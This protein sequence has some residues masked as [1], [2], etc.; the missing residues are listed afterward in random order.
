MWSMVMVAATLGQLDP[1]AGGTLPGYDPARWSPPP[2]ITQAVPAGPYEYHRVYDTTDAVAWA[3]MELETRKALPV[4]HPNYWSPDDVPFK[5]FV[6]I[7][8]NGDVS[9]VESNSLLVNSVCSQSP[10]IKLPEIVSGGWMLI[11][12]LRELAHDPKDLRRLLIVWNALHIGEPFFHA[13]LPKIG[14]TQQV[15]KT[16]PYE[17][18]DGKTYHARIH[19]P[20]PHVAQGYSLLEQATSFHDFPSFAPLVRADDFLRRM[21]SVYEG[22]LYYHAVGFIRRGHALSEAEI[23]HEVGL[24]VLLSREVS[25]DQRAGMFQSGVTGKPRT[26]EQVQGAIGLARVTFDVFDVDVDASRHAIYQLEDGVKKARGK[27][28]IFE[29]ANGLFGYFLT[30]GAGNLLV[31]QPA[32]QELVTDSTVPPPHTANL[33]P[34]ISCIRCHGPSGGVQEVRNDVATLLSGGP[35]EVNLFDDLGSKDERRA[36]VDRIAGRYSA[37]DTFQEDMGRSRN[38]YAD[39]VWRATLGSG[40]LGKTGVAEKAAANISNQYAD[41]WYARS[42]SVANVDADRALLEW[43]YRVKKPGDGKHVLR[44]VMPANRVDVLIDGRPVEFSDPAAEA[45]KR[46]LSIRRQDF[47]RIYAL[48]AYVITQNRGSK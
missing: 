41:Y 19:V 11:W 3:V 34:P 40:I 48:G 18:I 39:A 47:N 6:W 15:A 23:F 7:P 33:F 28:L 43:G 14:T 13:A 2:K 24:D 21:A 31:D 37:G 44:Q 27:E 35:G 17:H 32:P 29:R 22:G 30:D 12:D 36:T 5:R 26:V 10:V 45:L 25:A 4:T 1:A 42:K 16:L 38:S 9:W 20:A 8:P 46:G